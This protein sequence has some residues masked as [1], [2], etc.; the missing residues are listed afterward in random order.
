MIRLGKIHWNLLFLW[1]WTWIETVLYRR[2]CKAVALCDTQTRAGAVSLYDE[3]SAT[4]DSTLNSSVVCDWILMSTCVIRWRSHWICLFVL[5]GNMMPPQSAP[6][7]FTS[8]FQCELQQQHI[9]IFEFWMQDVSTIAWIIRC[10]NVCGAKWRTY[11]ALAPKLDSFTKL[12]LL[13]TVVG[14]QVDL[15]SCL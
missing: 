6:C 15:V 4:Y 13:I 3:W 5:A 7:C 12:D 9:K 14:F 1:L 10:L 11:L 2:Y 8:Y